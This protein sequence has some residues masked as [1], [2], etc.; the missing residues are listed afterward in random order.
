MHP[1]GAIRQ[2]GQ[3][4]NTIDIGRRFKYNIERQTKKRHERKLIASEFQ[5]DES[6]NN[7]ESRRAMRANKLVVINNEVAMLSG[8]QNK[9]K[10]ASWISHI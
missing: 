3:A 5:R 10:K 2:S 1:K 7:H 6:N 4:Q 8:G 9:E